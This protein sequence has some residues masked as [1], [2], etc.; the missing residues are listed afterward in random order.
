MLYFDLDSQFISSIEHRIKEI[1]D[2]DD[3][4]LATAFQNYSQ[5]MLDLAVISEESDFNTYDP[6]IREL[7]GVYM[8]RLELIKK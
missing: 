6:K 4:D 3:H 5:L 2:V 8:Q 1:G 7:V